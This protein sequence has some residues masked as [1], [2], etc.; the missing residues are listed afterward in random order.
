MYFFTTKQLK[1][2]T[3]FIL[4]IFQDSSSRSYKNCNIGNSQIFSIYNNCNIELLF[5]PVTRLYAK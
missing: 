2:Y 5:I 1:S 4:I 3:L